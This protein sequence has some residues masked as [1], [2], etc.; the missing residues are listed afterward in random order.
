M[1]LVG[2]VTISTHV[3]YMVPPYYTL[4]SVTLAVFRVKKR[5]HRYTRTYVRV[6]IRSIFPSYNRIIRVRDR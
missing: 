6:R 4:Q 1:E 3:E 5:I 2:G